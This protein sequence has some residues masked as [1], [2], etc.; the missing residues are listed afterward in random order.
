MDINNRFSGAGKGEVR[1]FSTVKMVAS[2][3][4]YSLYVFLDPQGGFRLVAT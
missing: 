1:E 2:R 4:M 3:N